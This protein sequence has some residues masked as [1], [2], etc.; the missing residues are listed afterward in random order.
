MDYATADD[1]ATAPSDYTAISTTQLTFNPGV[2][3]QPVTVLVNRD[4]TFE[5]AEQFFVNLTNASNATFTDNQGAG[6]ITN[7]DPV[8]TISIN[9]VTQAEGDGPG[10]TNF[11]FTISLTNPSYLPITVDYATAHGTA[12]WLSDHNAVSPT[13]VTFDPVQQL[14]PFPSRLTV[15][16]SS[17]RMRRSSSILPT[18]ATQRSEMARAWGRSTTTMRRRP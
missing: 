10:T 18:P 3:S 11:D 5:L 7:D 8:P 16:L 6:I 15:T 13:T 2:T 1:T 14:K 4:N 12:S 17:K 9:D